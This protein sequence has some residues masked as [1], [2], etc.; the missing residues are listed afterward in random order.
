V[1]LLAAWSAQAAET[2]PTDIQLP[3]TQPGEATIESVSKCDNCHAD[4]APDV[5][6][7]FTWAGSMMAQASRDPIFWATMA[8]G[9]QDFDGSGDLC[10]RCHLPKGW[11]AGRSTPT[12]GSGMAEGDANGV[13]CDLCHQMVNPDTSEH[14][15][16]QNSPFLA[17]D[18]GG[19]P[20]GFYGSGMSVLLDGNYKLGPYS[21]ADATHQFQQSE[22]HR[23]VDFCG[24]CHDVSNSAVGDLAHNHGAQVPLP[25]GS[26]SGVPGAPVEEKAAF[27]NFPYQYGVVERTFSEYKAGLLSQT[28]VSD[29]PSLPSD[30]KG[31]AIQRAYLA[32]ALPAPLTGYDYEDGALRYF[33]CQ[34][35]HMRATSGQGCNK[36]PPTRHDLP[37]HDMT[38][39]N[40]WM[41]DA[42]R[43]LDDLDQLR[44]GGGL[45]TGE[46]AA[47]TAGRLRALENL[48]DA[49]SVSVAGNAVKV[50]NLTGHKLITGYPEG[51]RMWLN[52]KWYD[53]A[54]A[55]VAEDG[56][57]GEITVD[58]EGTP[59]Q[60]ET[61]LLLNEPFGKVYEAHPAMTQEWANQ[62]LAL[63]KP[64]GTPLGFDRVTG[65]VALTLGQ[66]G[67]QAPGTYAET[68]H[69][70]LNNKMAKDNRIP[71]FGMSYDEALS[72]SA[73]PVPAE[74]YGNPGP[75]GTY[76]YWDEVILNPP[77]GADH[78]AISLLYQPTSWEYIQFLDLANTGEIAFLAD[79]GAQLLDAWL[80]TGMAA[81]YAMATTSWSNV[82]PACSDGLDNDG[83][84][85]TDHPADSGCA[86]AGDESE[87]ASGVAC[88]DR[89]DNDGDGLWD[90]PDDLGCTSLSGLL[91]DDEDGVP[92][93]IDNCP[94]VPNPG[95]EDFDGDG[96]GDACDEDDDDD[97]LP[98]V[99]ETNTGIFVSPS[100]TGT[101]PLDPDSDGDGFSDSEEVEAGSDPND[102]TSTP[103]SVIPIPS[104][105]PSG[106]AI[107][108][109]LLAIAALVAARRRIR[110]NP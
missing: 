78:A 43:Y 52:V 1:L 97:G 79:E 36:N 35:C 82:S 20:E 67:A 56:A 86:A 45:S 99:V 6:P 71:P 70:V 32:A 29:Y 61:L 50:V 51:R 26:F 93:A 14:P 12:D 34:T 55:L 102:E 28:L 92:D 5:E 95:Q 98:D 33:S 68:F 42:I 83:D 77:P 90:Y 46:I 3:G 91:E 47:L 25:S 2:V 59:T 69:F 96:S 101:D 81:P 87:N 21:D 44:I 37:H 53:A 40:Y 84:G 74:Q 19:P 4:Y 75:G 57:Y 104:L 94:D 23:S 105:T 49:A 22:F 109:M 60:V 58:I 13:Q 39:G 41:P 65:G 38:G 80:N 63:G 103:W 72:R 31:G 9:E 18:G 85:L 66:L 64:A 73:L 27:K 30:L 11:L 7:W 10:L 17:H 100:D 106:L 15:G 89:L 110:S 8:I 54:D 24:T 107:L 16:I 48:T 76:D 108:A 62:L 88:D